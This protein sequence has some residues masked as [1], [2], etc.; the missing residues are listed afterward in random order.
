M[1]SEATGIAK[2]GLTQSLTG[3]G[4]YS[5]IKS[6]VHI[7]SIIDNQIKNKV[8]EFAIAFNSLVNNASRWIK[9]V[10]LENIM[11]TATTNKP[12]VWLRGHDFS[13]ELPPFAQPRI[14][15]EDQCLCQLTEQGVH[16]FMEPIEEEL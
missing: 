1:L 6:D 13:A 15:I 14:P 7:M 4:G 8:Y 2:F 12:I 9:P 11:Q 10:E 3:I 16:H 5:Y